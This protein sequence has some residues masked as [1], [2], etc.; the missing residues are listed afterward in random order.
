MKQ[1]GDRRLLFYYDTAGNLCN[2][3]LA[4]GA[5]D[6]GAY[7]CDS[8]FG[9]FRYIKSGPGGA[10][11]LQAGHMRLNATNC[12]TVV[13]PGQPRAYRTQAVSDYGKV[14]EHVL[15]GEDPFDYM[16]YPFLY[17][18][19]HYDAETGL[20]YMR[21]RY[22]SPAQERFLAQDSA[23]FEDLPNRYIYAL[24]NPVMNYDRN[25][26]LSWLH[27]VAATALA[28]VGLV[29]AP[30]TAG[31]SEALAV[32]ADMLILTA[33]TSSEAAVALTASA[34][35]ESAVAAEG[36]EALS[37]TRQ[38]G[39]NALFFA[40][41]GGVS[42]VVQQANGDEDFSW[43]SFGKALG[44]GAVSGALFGGL[45]GGGVK[46]VS[47][48]FG[49]LRGMRPKLVNT[50]LYTLADVGAHVTDTAVGNAIGIS[51]ASLGVSALKG[52]AAGA[53]V[54]SIFSNF[55]ATTLLRRGAAGTQDVLQGWAA[56]MAT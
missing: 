55:S 3:T 46:G 34:V 53:V 5:G 8:Y 20:Q 1:A 33:E 11:E 37:M 17:G 4:D 22:Y 23:D 19:A 51:D 52:L 6:T 16:Q 10:V 26:H 35:E 2:S 49:P 29:L 13:K 50:A 42:N 9:G 31:G 28:V 56:D 48:I 18:A 41:A 21:S 38:I 24:S 40:G 54:G 39:G 12:T 7:K 14:S 32:E 43:A 44:A 47:K 15:L 45:Y 27:A 30:A 25:G 36:V